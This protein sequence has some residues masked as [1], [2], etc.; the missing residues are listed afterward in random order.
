[1]KILEDFLA[2]IKSQKEIIEALTKEVSALKSQVNKSSPINLDSEKV[3][4]HLIPHIDTTL[5]GIQTKTQELTSVVSKIPQEINNREEYGINMST[6]IWL[7]VVFFSLL[8][9]FWLAPKA[10]Q[11]AEYES[12]KFQLE[13]MKQQIQEFK[14]KNPK[15]GDKYFDI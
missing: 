14:S 2:E 5:K 6:K 12:T 11:K 7:S 1:M 13:R 9:G 10:V 4:K 8:A 15:L 3:A